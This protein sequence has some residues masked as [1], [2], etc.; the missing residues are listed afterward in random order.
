MNAALALDRARLLEVES[1]I[2]KLE[3]HLAALHSEKESI[4]RRLDEYTYPVLTLPNEIV[5]EIF[6]HYLPPY[7]DHP[8]L[9]GSGSP[10]YL[11]G[12]CRLWRN[13]ALHSPALWRSIRLRWPSNQELE[14]T[15]AWLQRSGGCPVS[16]C[17]NFKTSEDAGPEVASSLLQ[18]ALAHHSRWEYIEFWYLAP[19]FLLSI[20]V[21]APNLVRLQLHGDYIAPD[22]TSAQQTISLHNAELLRVVYLWEIPYGITSLPWNQLTSLVLRGTTFTAATPIL[23]I[24]QNLRSC[25]LSLIGIGEGIHVQL[26]QL[27]FMSVTS[28]VHHLTHND[29]GLALFTLPSLRKLEIDQRLLGVHAVERLK[30]FISRSRC[31][32][33]RLR[34]GFL[35]DESVVNACCIA[36]PFVDVDSIDYRPHISWLENEEYWDHATGSSQGTSMTGSDSD[37][38]ADSD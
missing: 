20:C 21:S 17:I 25:K 8:P 10:T 3:A 36:F 34:I 11:L 5:T 22:S 18:M 32:L 19:H 29:T 37:L 38:E 15:K 16:L 14:T 6:I 12:I 2:P 9:I 27:E 33:E 13:V 26:P 31:S 28:D 7:P 35:T 23:K 24:A 30:A 1:E 4:H